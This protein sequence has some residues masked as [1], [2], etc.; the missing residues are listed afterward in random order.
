[1]VPSP[2]TG[3]GGVGEYSIPSSRVLPI[4]A[5]FQ[6]RQAQAVILISWQPEGLSPQIPSAAALIFANLIRYAFA[7]PD[8]SLAG[9]GLAV[10]GP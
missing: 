8:A 2:G 7:A 10:L 4:R 1:M 3:D 5:N 6:Y 9:E